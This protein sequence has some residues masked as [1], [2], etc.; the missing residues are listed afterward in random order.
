MT[1]LRPRRTNQQKWRITT[2]TDCVGIHYNQTQA[3]PLD[4]V[5]TPQSMRYYNKRLT[6]FSAKTLEHVAHFKKVYFGPAG[7]DY[8]WI[9]RLKINQ[10]RPADPRETIVLERVYG[11]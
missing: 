5:V 10:Y 8:C 4:A 7:P 9:A 11:T 1:L 6:T 3:I 2:L